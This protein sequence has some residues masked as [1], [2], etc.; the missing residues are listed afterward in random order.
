VRALFFAAAAADAI[1]RRSCFLNAS[2]SLHRVCF[3][4]ILFSRFFLRWD[5]EAVTPMFWRVG[6]SGSDV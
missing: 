4:M 3:V 2:E 5:L 1:E 6:T